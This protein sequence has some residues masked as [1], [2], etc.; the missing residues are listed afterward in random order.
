[1]GSGWYGQFA[2]CKKNKLNTGIM[3]KVLIISEGKCCCCFAHQ[4]V[5]KEQKKHKIRIK[6][7]ECSHLDRPGVV[8]VGER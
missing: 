2:G 3:N 4:M 8:V 6:H 5:M 7:A 1:M